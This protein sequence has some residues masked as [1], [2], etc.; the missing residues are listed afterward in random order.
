MST[1]LPIDLIRDKERAFEALPRVCRAK[2]KKYL[3]TEE[4]SRSINV[5]LLIYLNFSTLLGC[6]LSDQEII[7]LTAP[8]KNNFASIWILAGA[9][10]FRAWPSPAA[11]PAVSDPFA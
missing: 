5:A 2:A 3:G 8:W 4:S 1:T 10:A 9:R 11:Y 6:V 7:K